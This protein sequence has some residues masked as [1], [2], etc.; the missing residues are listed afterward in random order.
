MDFLTLAHERYSCRRFSDKA[1][2]Q[3]KI[4]KILEAAIASPTAVN[5][6]PYKIWVIQKQEDLEKIAQTTQYTFNAPMI[7]A[8]GGKP[9]EAWV[10]KY[11]GKTSGV[12]D[13]CSVIVHMLLKA[14][15]IGVGTTW[16]MHFNPEKAREAFNIPANVIPVGFIMLGY[17]AEDAMPS[18]MH[19]TFRPMD[20][21]VVKDSF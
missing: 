12:S 4:D 17:P 16:V 9:D 13:A 1:V 19:S 10:R 5:Y 18:D 15:E 7:F 8:V 21:V 3:E 20:E 2:E 11:D 6:Q 14:T